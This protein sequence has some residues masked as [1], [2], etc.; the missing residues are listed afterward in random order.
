MLACLAPGMIGL[1][2]VMMIMK[3]VSY[4]QGMMQCRYLT[5]PLGKLAATL[6]HGTLVYSWKANSGG[7]GARAESRLERTV[8]E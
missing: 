8:H 1:A 3:F 7:P 5:T 2:I 4:R 6:Q